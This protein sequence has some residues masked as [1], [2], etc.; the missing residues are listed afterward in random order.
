MCPTPEQV[1]AMSAVQL[2]V[3]LNRVRR[4][5]A[6]QLMT[7]RKSRRRDPRAHDFGLFWLVDSRGRTVVRGT[8]TEV[9]IYLIHG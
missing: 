9:H 4:I 2:K 6:R 8:I 3:Y 7:L 5:A 1:A